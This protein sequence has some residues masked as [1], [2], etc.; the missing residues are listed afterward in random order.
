M[1]EVKQSENKVQGAVSAATQPSRAKY[2]YPY[3]NIKSSLEVARVIHEKGG[4]SCT[5]DQL[6]AFL[7]YK[8][9]KSG[10]YLTRT[11]AARQFGFIRSGNG[12]IVVTERAQKI[13]SPVMPEDA[14]I[15]KSDAFLGVE[16]FNTIYERFKGLTL[17]SEGGLKN[18]LTQNYS[19]TND[20][21]G[22]AI[23]VLYESA[24]HAGFFEAVDDQSKLIKPQI[25]S[26]DQPQKPAGPPELKDHSSERQKPKGTGGGGGEPPGIHSAIIGLLRELPASGTTWKKSKK[27]AFKTAF[28]ATLDF[29][30]PTDEDANEE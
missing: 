13:L 21:V 10:T 18:L 20:R 27:D 7:G 14:V 11:S 25:K 3:Y 30:Y 23:R 9:V 26:I 1:A 4:G 29:I 5:P 22:P 15:A 12:E 24:D 16:L 28:E 6:A 17:P 8:S 19:L 2:S